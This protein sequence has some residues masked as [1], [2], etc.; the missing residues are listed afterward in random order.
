MFL[1]YKKIVYQVVIFF[2]SCVML[3]LKLGCG[4]YELGSVIK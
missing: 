1:K 4:R 3:N 2:K